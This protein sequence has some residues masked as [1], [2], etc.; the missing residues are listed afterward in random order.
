[1]CP[2][3]TCSAASDEGDVVAVEPEASLKTW[4]GH[5]IGLHASINQHPISMH[6]WALSRAPL[7]A[8]RNT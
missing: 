1:M 6:A 8:P 3:Q 5:N 4:I 7:M 2:G